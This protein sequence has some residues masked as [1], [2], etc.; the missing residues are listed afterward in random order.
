MR[1]DIATHAENHH[2]PRL[3]VAHSPLKQPRAAWSS[4]SL[5]VWRWDVVICHFT[6]DLKPNYH[7]RPSVGVPIKAKTLWLWVW[8]MSMPL[9]FIYHR[10][11][12]SSVVFPLK[13]HLTESCSDW[14]DQAVRNRVPPSLRHPEVRVWDPIEINARTVENTNFESV[15]QIKTISFTREFKFNKYYDDECV[16]VCVSMCKC[17][18]SYEE[19]APR[20]KDVLL[21][22]LKSCSHGYQSSALIT[23]PN[24]WCPPPSLCHVPL[25]PVPVLIPSP[26]PAQ[27]DSE[28][29]SSLLWQ[30]FVLAV[31][32]SPHESATTVLC[33]QVVWFAQT[34]TIQVAST[35]LRS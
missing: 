29:T 13:W 24:P 28:T 17:D 35:V 26:F 14:C 8:L 18:Y 21:L 1:I 31:A 32:F 12:Q 10:K 33:G 5:S 6:E 2:T 9:L 25:P 30:H 20:E 27:S 3:S 15:A 22:L 11:R 16:Y 34:L 7:P 4:R 23:H 19:V